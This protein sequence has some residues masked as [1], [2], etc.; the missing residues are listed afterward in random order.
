MAVGVCSSSSKRSSLHSISSKRL[1]ISERLLSEVMTSPHRND[2]APAATSSQGPS[3]QS[4]IELGLFTL[5]WREKCACSL[6]RP[7][8][9]QADAPYV[10]LTPPSDLFVC[11]KD[12]FLEA[13][14]T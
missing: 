13:I 5:R 10:G 4:R 7:H 2:K 6:L 8:H 14:A 3:W 1:R 11:A 12:L 9:L